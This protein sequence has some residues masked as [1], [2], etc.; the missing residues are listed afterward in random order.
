ML[1]VCEAIVSHREL[2]ALFHELGGRLRQVVSFDYLS[3]VLHEA[4]NNTMRLH[5][6]EAAEP[7]PGPLVIVLSVEDDPAGLVWQSQQSLVTASVR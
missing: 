4:A 1:A 5:L 3:M 6:L 7:V 2:P